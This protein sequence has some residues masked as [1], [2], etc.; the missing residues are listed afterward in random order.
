[1]YDTVMADGSDAGSRAKHALLSQYLNERQRR[2]VA[3]AQLLGHGGNRQVVADHWFEPGRP[4]HKGVPE[5]EGN[6]VAAERVRREG[7]GRK[8]KSEQ[9][10]AVVKELERLVDPATRGDPMSPLRW[11]SKTEF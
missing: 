1:M 3:D 5:L 2:L 7:G 10:P 11:T 4:L 9:D 6:E 8:R